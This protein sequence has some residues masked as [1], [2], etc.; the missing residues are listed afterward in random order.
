MICATFVSIRVNKWVPWWVA[1]IVSLSGAWP[2]CQST[3]R[4]SILLL[5]LLSTG[6]I[7]CVVVVVVVV[8]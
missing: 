1:K 4:D 3:V 7:Y 8:E 2:S 5:H 6:L